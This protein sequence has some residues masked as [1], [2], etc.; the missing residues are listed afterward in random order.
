MAILCCVP[1]IHLPNMPQELIDFKFQHLSVGNAMQNLAF[2]S[3]VG[4]MLLIVIVQTNAHHETGTRRFV[5]SIFS[6]FTYAVH[7]ASHHLYF[8]VRSLF[9]SRH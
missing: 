4:F 8:M 9:V 3:L 5:L 7:A 2:Y 6:R 1:I